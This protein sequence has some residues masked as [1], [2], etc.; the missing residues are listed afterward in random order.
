M[1]NIHMK[2]TRWGDGQFLYTPE[3]IIFVLD[4]CFF[5]FTFS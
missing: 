5:F 3:A 2:F 1:L 4:D